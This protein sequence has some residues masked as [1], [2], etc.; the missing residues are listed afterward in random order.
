MSRAGR[1]VIVALAGEIDRLNAPELREAIERAAGSDTGTLGVV[2]DLGDVR[3]LDS[4]GVH[5][6]H[7]LSRFLRR[8]GQRLTVVR[9][10]ARTPAEVLALTGIDEIAPVLEDLDAA[11][12]AVAG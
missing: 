3:Y 4:S 8:R 12:E 10:L 11:I 5:L 1:A 9:P 7:A 2:C 6:L